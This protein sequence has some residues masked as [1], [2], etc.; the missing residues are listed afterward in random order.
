MSVLPIS[1]ST[2]TT[3]SIFEKF[4]AEAKEFNLEAVK[5]DQSIESYAKGNID[6]ANLTPELSMFLL[7][8]ESI[9]A[10]AEGVINGVKTLQSTQI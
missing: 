6:I 5:M 7:K 8:F 10:I 9:K 1:P 4:V 2:I 3:Q